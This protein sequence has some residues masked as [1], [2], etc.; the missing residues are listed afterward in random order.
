MANLLGHL[1]LALLNLLAC[2][3]FFGTVLWA[4]IGGGYVA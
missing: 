1:L 3:L 2:S 4:L